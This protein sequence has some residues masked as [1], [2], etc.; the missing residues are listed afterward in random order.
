M[1][2][3]L[4]FLLCLSIMR[5]GVAQQRNTN[6]KS[7]LDQEREIMQIT[8][9]LFEGEVI[10]TTSYPNAD[11]TRLYFSSI[12]QVTK[13]LSGPP[14][15][16]T[17]QVTYKGPRIVGV[18]DTPGSFSIADDAHSSDIH[19]YLPDR[20]TVLLFCRPLPVNYARNSNKSLSR[21]DNTIP[22][23]VVGYAS[24]RSYDGVSSTV[25]GNFS[26]KQALYQYLADKHHVP[27][28][29][30]E[31][32]RSNIT[33]SRRDSLN[34]ANRKKTEE[35]EKFIRELRKSKMIN[36][37]GKLVIPTGSAQITYTIQNPTI[38]GTAHRHVS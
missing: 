11:S 15:V 7:T 4:L 32:G 14:L 25:G 26:D 16:G 20:T 19:P 18:G 6:Q 36:N 24:Y 27:F 17:V 22:L 34:K 1:K 28:T 23:E 5:F 9:H 33:S 35:K 38:S 30:V 21:V 13:T 29:A 3:F 10:S 12:I 37:N 31:L 2:H 8:S